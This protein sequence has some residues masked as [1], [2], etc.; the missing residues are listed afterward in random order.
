[1]A[2]K[3]RKTLAERLDASGKSTMDIAYACGVHTVT[4]GKWRAGRAKPTVESLGRLA[5]LLGVS[6]DE[7]VVE[8]CPE[9]ND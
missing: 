3:T 7:L 4:V 8:W 5:M 2:T 6:C 9:L 1:M